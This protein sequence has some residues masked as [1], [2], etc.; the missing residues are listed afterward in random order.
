MIQT[1]KLKH[2]RDFSR[3]LELAEKIAWVGF[4]T[5]T[6]DLNTCNII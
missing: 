2:E 5:K 3:E 1:Y 6:I 4:H